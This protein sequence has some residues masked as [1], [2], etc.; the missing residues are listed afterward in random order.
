MIGG[1][2]W[3]VV[4]PPSSGGTVIVVRFQMMLLSPCQLSPVYFDT[5]TLDRP[6]RTPPSARVSQC[7]MLAVLC[8]T[9]GCGDEMVCRKLVLGLA[10]TPSSSRPASVGL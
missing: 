2:N 1:W 4:R 7:A 8:T 10:A 5:W 9:Y 6:S 3:T